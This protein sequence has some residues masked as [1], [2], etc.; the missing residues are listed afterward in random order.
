MGKRVNP[1][2]W[3]AQWFSA[4]PVMVLTPKQAHDAKSYFRFTPTCAYPKG[5]E[6]LKGEVGFL[7]CQGYR[8]IQ[9]ARVH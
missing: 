1:G 3:Y 6:V 4:R 5:V 9:Q 2:V 8:V 7:P